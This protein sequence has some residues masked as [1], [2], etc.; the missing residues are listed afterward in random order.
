[1][2]LNDFLFGA[3]PMDK[4]TTKDLF[5]GPTTTP[6]SMEAV[7]YSARANAP[8]QRQMDDQ[9]TWESMRN[10]GNT[11]Y[12]RS[13]T[14]Y[15]DESNRASQLGQQRGDAFGAQGDR[16]AAMMQNLGDQQG[17]H[18]AGFNNAAGG[19]YQN[20]LTDRNSALGAMGRL[21][22]FYQQGPGPSAAEAQMRQGND[23]NMAQSLALAH[24]GRGVGNN[25]AAMRQA[26][27]GNA[28][29]GQQ[30][31]QQLGT[32]RANEASNWRQQQLGAMGMEQ[33]GLQGIRGQDLSSMGQNQQ[34]GLGYGQLQGQLY[35]QGQQNQLGYGAL[36][37]QQYSGGEALRNQILS[38]QQSSDTA[39][40]GADRGVQVGM[41]QVGQQQDAANMGLA[42]S[43][44]GGA[45]MMSD[46]RAKKDIKKESLG[47]ILSTDSPVMHTGKGGIYRDA[48]IF[49]AS[50]EQPV[51]NYQAHAQRAA[52]P[53]MPAQ[54]SEPTPF[55]IVDPYSG[56]TD[57][58]LVDPWAK[59]G[60]PDRT[61]SY[62]AHNPYVTSDTEQKKNQIRAEGFAQAMQQGAAQGAMQG[63]AQHADLR[64]AQGYSYNYKNPS[65]VGADD[66]TYY[67]PMAQ[68]LEKTPA[69]AST[70]VN[71]PKG[72]AVDT[73]RLAMVNTSAISEQQKRIDQ[74]EQ[75]L[76]NRAKYAPG[77]QLPGP[78]QPASNI[79]FHQSGAT[80][81]DAMQA[82]PYG[83]PTQE[84]ADK[85][86]M[87]QSILAGGR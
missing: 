74:L 83:L 87:R 46:I 59:G 35:G 63:G 54:A 72:K 82:G 29:A 11:M 26:Q 51:G 45:V 79:G 55:G 23:A 34:T 9:S 43:L 28:A 33:Q 53:D 17:A 6:S 78:T 18:Q 4:Q 61:P 16:N 37:G 48:R 57:N 31:N 47:D 39:K 24:S 73:G 64:P 7:D 85:A 1:M 19:D 38:G 67:G 75:L 49:D 68:D 76:N 77:E 2:G 12:G 65:A 86:R 41:A 3:N 50:T 20:S 15:R 8:A 69:G 58:G 22:N 81:I 71:T 36:A 52:I 32:L 70:V 25:A 80:G 44:V 56:T 14:G 10:N 60:T 42:A 62:M 27:F 66:R 84:E 30:M 21:Q 13:V 40:Y 5:N